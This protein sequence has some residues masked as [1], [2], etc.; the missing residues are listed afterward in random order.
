M[1]SKG[2]GSTVDV[3]PPAD[4]PDARGEC[5]QPGQP[6]PLGATWDGR[7]ANF[8]I[9][10]EQATRIDLCLFDAG[11]RERRVTLP[12]VTGFC[13]HGYLPRVTPG[14]R[15]GYRVHGPW[16]PG[17]GHRFNPSKL[18]IDP[19]ARAIDGDVRWH[20]AVFP[21]R[22]GGP[23]DVIDTRD[24]APFVPRSIVIDPAFDWAGDTSP[25]TPLADTLL[26]ETH[27]KGITMRHPDIPPPLRG[28]YAGLAH[29]AA[30]EHLRRLGVTAV[31]LL[32]VH[33]FVHARHV[34]ER[35]LRNYWG[36]DSLG[37]FAPHHEYAR[38]RAPG[39]QVS[40][41]KRMVAALHAAGLEVILDVAYTHTAE[42]NHLGPM[43]AFK[44]IANGAYYRTA[45][46]DPR[47][48]VD[49]TGTGNTLNVRHPHVIQLIMDSLRY[50][51]L[52]MHVDGFRFD[53]GAALGREFHEV[54]RLATFFEVVQQDPV[55]S[56]VKLIVEPWDLGEGGYQVGNFPVLWSE[57][58]GRYRDTVRDYWRSAEAMIPDLACRLA[59]SSDLFQDDGRRPYASINFVTSHDGFTLRDLVSYD[60]KH[61]EANGEDNRDGDTCNRSWN[62]GVEGDTDRADVTELRARQQR[63]LLATLLLSQGVPMLLG[64]DEIGR[65]QRGNNNAYCHD[66][67]VSWFDWEHADRSLLH[68]T[69]RLIAFRR[70]HPIF[71]RRQWFRGPRQSTG[72]G[73]I[74]WLRP[75]ASPMAN[76][77]W[78]SAGL[79]AIAMFL[80]GE[81]L[82]DCDRTG[83]AV[84]DDSF[85]L[86]FSAK[87]EPVRF[88]LAGPPFALAW[89]PILDTMTACV[90]VRGSRL[91]AGAVVVLAPLS[92]RVFRRVA[93][94]P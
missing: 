23:D 1:S 49:Y 10:S 86:C 88:S 26:Y 18:L 36:Y 31:E 38:D 66:C 15:Y 85:L 44:G 64:G 42:G 77:D 74:A 14:Q 63:N 75:D 73:D 27:V 46:D 9:F 57:W 11:G 71:R 2:Q 22:I 53:L 37:F 28:T 79:G 69:R 52:A 47:Y 61:N 76:G 89:E 72:V 56:R 60:V 93:A 40:E 13:W 5:V 24:S 68:F 16:A 80:N 55:I 32:P 25:G 50:W 94:P 51:V 6:Y 87:R 81:A 34:R 67:E 29:P 70:R 92:L 62:C 19:Y 82:A 39:G 30:I 17:R 78:Q 45:A 43:L 8:S 21:Y 35:G 48:Y 4:A 59:G 91:E 83:A 12:E 65:T 3:V 33:E 54:D 7:G 41:F 84:T 20:D 90:D 58:N